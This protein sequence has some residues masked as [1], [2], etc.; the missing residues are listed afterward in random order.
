MQAAGIAVTA[1]APQSGNYAESVGYENVLTNPHALDD[2]SQIDQES[3]MHYAMQ[4]PVW[5]KA[6]GNLY[7]AI[8][9]VYSATYAAGIEGMFPT[10]GS[11]DALFLTNKLPRYMLA[12]DMPNYASLTADQKL[13]Y[14]TPET[15]LLK[16]S[17][18]VKLVADAGAHP[19]N[20]TS[21]VA[22]LDCAA[23][24]PMRLAALKND[25]RTWTPKSPMLMCG[26]NG[27]NEVG[28]YNAQ[29]TM[30]YFAAHG[31]AANTV[32]VLDVDSPVAAGDPY[33]AAKTAFA[34]AR[35][36]VVAANDN[37]N[38]NDNYHGYTAFIGCSVAVRD[39][40]KNY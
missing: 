30:A 11:T 25:L 19:C 33:A 24:A 10:K 17:Y 9:D 4:I 7:S 27:D 16:T 15:S 18:V 1:A 37:P 2:L 23:T 21:A 13:Y 6:Y 34:K 35:Q 28:F 36:R 22:P 29:L 20:V 5:Q 39:F 14:G 26:G 3:I 12:N 40:F 32:S 31:L 8:T 38:S